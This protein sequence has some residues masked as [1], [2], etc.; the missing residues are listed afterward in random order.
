MNFQTE[1]IDIEQLTKLIINEEA[2]RNFLLDIQNAYRIQRAIEED[3]ND[4]LLIGTRVIDDIIER[5]SK[6][7]SMRLQYVEDMESKKN[8]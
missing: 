8:K 5:L 2:I 3:P 6:C 4:R 1:G 7:E